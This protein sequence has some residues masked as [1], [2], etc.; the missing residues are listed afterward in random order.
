[1]N[2]SITPVGVEIWANQL[3]SN[4]KTDQ[5]TLSPVC[6]GGQNEAPIK[7]RSNFVQWRLYLTVPAHHPP[8]YLQTT[9][10][11]SPAPPFSG[12]QCNITT[13]ASASVTLK[14]LQVGC[15]SQSQKAPSWTVLLFF[16]TL[17]PSAV[18][19][20]HSSLGLLCSA[21]WPIRAPQLEMNLHN[22]SMRIDF[23]TTQ[24]L[25]ENWALGEKGPKTLK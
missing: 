11:Q 16:M 5:Q 6:T 18:L 24:C 17:N 21:V 25:I 15:L 7:R 4:I 3:L 14:Q 10:K 23:F 19:L 13:L 12:L 1:M 9:T 22:H 20:T 2:L 8:C